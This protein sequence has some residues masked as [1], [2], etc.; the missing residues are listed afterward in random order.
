MRKGHKAADVLKSS[1]SKSE[2][3]GPQKNTL[4]DGFKGKKLYL[5][6]AKPMKRG[7]KVCHVLSWGRF[8]MKQPG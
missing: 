5:V 3:L 8:L 1:A 2:A 7:P 4:T 6:E